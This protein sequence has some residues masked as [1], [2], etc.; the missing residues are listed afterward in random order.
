MQIRENGTKRFILPFSILTY[1]KFIFTT[2][3]KSLQAAFIIEGK[4][5]GREIEMTLLKCHNECN[6]ATI[7][8][9]Y[10]DKLSL[11]F[12]YIFYLIN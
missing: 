9:S 4:T 6:F 12:F 8:L 2:N 1:I 11:V 7:I 3:K 10:K 5:T